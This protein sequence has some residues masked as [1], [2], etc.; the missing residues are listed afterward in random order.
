MGRRP[1]GRLR[2]HLHD[3]PLA[4]K[5]FWA[6][7][8]R[9]PHHRTRRPTPYTYIAVGLGRGVRRP[10]RLQRDA[11]RHRRA[12]EGLHSTA[13]AA[14]GIVEALE[15][16]THHALFHAVQG[17]PEDTAHEDPAQQQIFD[18]LVETSGTR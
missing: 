12:G 16:P 1:S 7:H 5:P 14:D 15:L 3:S 4:G 2:R 9:R 17:H 11:G 10:A 6:R 8:G 13:R 18:A